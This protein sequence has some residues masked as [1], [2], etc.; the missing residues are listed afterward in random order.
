MH[1][2]P[3]AF[4]FALAVLFRLICVSTL[5]DVSDAILCSSFILRMTNAEIGDLDL[6][7]I[8]GGTT[9]RPLCVRDNTVETLET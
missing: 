9:L 7:A 2:A 1:N 6:E 8:R 5:C 4:A 3:F